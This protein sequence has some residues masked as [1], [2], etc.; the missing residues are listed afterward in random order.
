MSN[1]LTAFDQSFAEQLFERQAALQPDLKDYSPIWRQKCIRDILFHLQFLE[2]AI[3]AESTALFG[4]YFG[5]VNVIL[6]QR[7]MTDNG[8][9][10]FLNV[11]RDTFKEMLIEPAYLEILPYLQA[12][13]DSLADLATVS[14]QSAIQ[15]ENPFYAEAKEYFDI[16]LQKDRQAGLQKVQ[17]FVAR[18]LDVKDIYLHIFQPV[19]YE[20][21]RLWQMNRI[22]IAQEHFGTALTQMAMSQLYPNVFNGEVSGFRMIA[23][24]VGSEFH[25]VGIR[26]VTDFFAMA[27]WETYYLGANM[28]SEAI[29]LAI[30]E[31]QADLLAL[32]ITLSTQITKLRDLIGEIRGGLD[33]EIKILVGG[34]PFNVDPKAWQFVG[35]DGYAAD[36]ETAV[37]TA[38]TLVRW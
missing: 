32:S 27:G 36:A 13:W 26:M 38:F 22:S 25:E 19:Q 23:A 29:I 6:Q 9:D 14:D 37:D 28:P 20:L 33:H 35:A 17:S 11:L 2:Q 8:L 1:P 18:G 31:Y 30:N 15:P 5:W 4:D 16:L 3:A 12:G 24:C 10:Q 7:G 34:H 21:G